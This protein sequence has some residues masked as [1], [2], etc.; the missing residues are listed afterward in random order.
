MRKRGANGLLVKYLG[1]CTWSTLGEGAANGERLDGGLP[2]EIFS[3]TV[4]TLRAEHDPRVGSFFLLTVWAGTSDQR[5][6]WILAKSLTAG[7]MWP[8]GALA[9]ARPP[10]LSITSCVTSAFHF[11]VKQEMGLENL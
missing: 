10:A 1:F 9:K 3:I 2:V 4:E 8:E 11:S 7:D 6:S 5:W